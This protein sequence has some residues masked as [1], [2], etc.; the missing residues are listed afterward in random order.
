MVIAASFVV[1]VL[2]K[3][4]QRDLD[5]QFNS[6]VDC[7]FYKE[8]TQADVLVEYNDAKIDKNS[9]VK[10]Y[11]FC[12]ENLLSDGYGDTKNIVLDGTDILPCKDWI[13][14]WLKYESL[15]TAI[16]ILVPTV[17]IVLT[18]VL[19]LL[20][21]LER[22]KSMSDSISSS[23]WKSF[24][25][26][27]INTAIILLVV[28]LHISPITQN[29]PNFWIFAGAYDDLSPHWY[30]AVGATIIFCMI[31][32]IFTPHIASLFLWLYTRLRR[33]CDKKWCTGGKKTKRL[34][35]K[36]FINLYVGP[37]F[38]I[39]TRYSEILTSIF[40]ILIYSAGMPILYL[41][42]FLFLIIT[43]WVDKALILRLYRNPPHIDLYVSKLFNT[44]ILIGMVVHFGFAIWIYGNPDIL[45]SNY[46]VFLGDISKWLEALL[47]KTE[48]SFNE[49]IVRRM[50][51]PHNIICLIFLFGIGL[52]CFIRLF[53]VGII[54]RAAVWCCGGK[55][56]KKVQNISVYD[57]LALKNIYFNYQLR[58]C[59]YM[60]IKNGNMKN[61]YLL[62]NYFEKMMRKD[63][64]VIRRK[65][66]LITGEVY[67]YI[68]NAE[69]DRNIIPV[70]KTINMIEKPLIRGDTSYNITH[71]LDFKDLAYFEFILPFI[72][73]QK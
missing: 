61:E 12:Y 9:R 30:S 18:F 54:I 44:I 24:I 1:V 17:N 13:E 21:E 3:I 28:N 20:T 68:S 70:M 53:F 35:K 42:C 6:N 23:M 8:V 57:C 34:T 69:F 25:L 32:N 47:S 52:V 59:Q 43:Y 2:S 40:V 55:K 38:D 37:S 11:C 65:L 63:R 45:T 56:Y 31:L 5:N 62:R 48:G 39:G 19:S 7:S 73:S 50:L 16:I 26:Q 41:L 71:I 14:V 49:E 67:D 60:K 36:E 29:H 64:E 66:Q 22:N 46:I 27:L 10:L 15:N 51:Y 72:K 58:K 33:A 4:A